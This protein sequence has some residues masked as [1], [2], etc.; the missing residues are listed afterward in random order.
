MHTY[1]N[2]KMVGK[3]SAKA[4]AIKGY[5]KTCSH[6]GVCAREIYQELYTAYGQDEILH[7]RACRVKKFKCVLYLV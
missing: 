1:T 4:D 3:R 5:I 7:M 6:L 2:I